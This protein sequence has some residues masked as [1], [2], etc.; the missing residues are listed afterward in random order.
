MSLFTFILEYAGGT[1]ISQYTALSPKEALYV[2]ASNER[3]V[4]TGQWAPL[5][6]DAVF[7]ALGCRTPC[8]LDNLQYAWCVTAVGAGQLALLNIVKT[9][10][11]TA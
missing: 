4:L 11:E 10:R 2:W 6:V 5:T 1:Y 3:A 8:A 9:E 7:E